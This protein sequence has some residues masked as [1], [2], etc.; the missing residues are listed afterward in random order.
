MIIRNDANGR[1]TYCYLC[2]L[3][4]L[5]EGNRSVQMAERLRYL[6]HLSHQVHRAIC[7]L[8]FQFAMVN[9][10]IEN[11]NYCYVSKCTSKLVYS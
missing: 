8:S 9:F 3:T 7:K 10:T 11:I 6:E 2:L 1:L 5:R 4:G